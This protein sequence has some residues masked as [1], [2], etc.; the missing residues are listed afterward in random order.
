MPAAIN[1]AFRKILSV[2][3]ESLDDNASRADDKTV[4]GALSQRVVSEQLYANAVQSSN[5]A[6]LTTDLDGK[7]TSWNPGAERLFGYSAGEMIGREVEILAPPE[8][9]NEIR[10]IREK[11]IAGQRTDDFNTVRTGKDGRPVHVVIDV[12]PLRAT[13]G[14]LLGSSALMRDVT[15]QRLAE[16][17]FALAVESCP[18]GMFIIDRSGRMV[19]VNGEVEKL[20]GYRREE[21]IGQAIEMLVPSEIR[22]KHKQMRADYVS[23]PESRRMGKS[24]QLSG[25]RKDGSEFPVEVELNPI[26]IRD[27]LLILGVVV[28]I[29]ERRRAEQRKNDFVSTVSHE[30]RTPMTSITA[31]LSL[32]SAGGAG[33][34]PDPAHRLVS[35]A[36]SN[37]QRLVRLINDILDIEKIE[38][39]D[40]TFEIWPIEVE[41]MVTQS[42]EANRAYAAEFGVRIRLEA[43][44]AGGVVR[45]DGDRLEQVVTNL[46]SNAIKFSPRG[47]EVVVAVTR[48]EDTIRIAVRDHGPGIPDDF[49]PRIFERFAQANIG[50]THGK[51]GSGL[52]LSIVKQIVARLGGEVGFESELGRGTMFY[53]N[54]PAAPMDSRE[55]SLGKNQEVA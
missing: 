55:Q 9:R 46:L 52:G 45:A 35:I 42:I 15:A 33:R 14:E 20:F 17:L 31:A 37:G 39:G 21:L 26:R 47:K 53:V 1:R 48:R 40:T 11:V 8:R 24:R 22:A 30:L 49:K 43:H 16:D 51:N 54:L 25:A 18:S 23:A 28:D 13:S 10:A 6:F 32:L 3:L 36:H 5:L 41:S 38:S 4:P 34:L 50:E 27:G 2:L 19:M 44:S 7:I 29:S 12:S